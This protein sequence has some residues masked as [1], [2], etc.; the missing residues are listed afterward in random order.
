MEGVYFVDA[1][2]DVDIEQ[3]PEIVKPLI[4]MAFF[5]F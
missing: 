3:E 2:I 4:D 1:V 5:E